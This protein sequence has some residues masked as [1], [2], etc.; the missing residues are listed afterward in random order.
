MRS[1]V[2]ALLWLCVSPTAS[3][4]DCG[5]YPF[6]AGETN[7]PWADYVFDGRVKAVR[8]VERGGEPAGTMV[9]FEVT[10]VY[11]GAKKEEVTVG[12]APY[13]MV[14]SSGYPFLCEATYHVNAVKKE[15]PGSYKELSGLYTDQCMHVKPLSA[16][17]L[18]AT[19]VE[20]I[21]LNVPSHSTKSEKDRL[22]KR[23]YCVPNWGPAL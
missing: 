22:W 20:R 2:C 19:E 6:K 18:D 4:F 17:A 11:K 1:L 13:G 9:V 21:L 15:W 12:T 23:I 3:A 10:K 5:K 8:T 7:P 16:N 14:D